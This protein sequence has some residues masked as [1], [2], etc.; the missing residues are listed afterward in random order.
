MQNIRGDPYV[1]SLYARNVTYNVFQSH[2]SA[3]QC[4]MARYW[5]VQGKLSVQ[6]CSVLLNIVAYCWPWGVIFANIDTHTTTHVAPY[7]CALTRAS[8][9]L[10]IEVSTRDISTPRNDTTVTFI[11]ARFLRCR[12]C[13]CIKV[14]NVIRCQGDAA[15]RMAFCQV[16]LLSWWQILDCMIRI[17]T[18][19]PGLHPCLYSDFNHTFLTC[20]HI[21]LL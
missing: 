20:P 4:E 3:N 9:N 18:T 1:T 15:C 12:W 21:P 2:R 19:K 10:R 11:N 8:E 13:F 6:D 17:G 16:W 5:C 14:V 7:H